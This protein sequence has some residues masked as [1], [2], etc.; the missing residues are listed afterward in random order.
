MGEPIVDEPV[1]AVAEP[2][3]E[4]PVAAV[5]EPIVEEPVAVQPVVEES[6]EPILV[7]VVEDVPAAVEDPSEPLYPFIYAASLEMLNSMG[8]N[9]DALCRSALIAHDGNIERAVVALLG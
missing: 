5:S 6:S 2:I 4:E 7:E 3:V 1:A 9:D 8:F